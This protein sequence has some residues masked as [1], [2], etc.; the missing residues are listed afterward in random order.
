M[1]RVI[2]AGNILGDPYTLQRYT[3]ML[4]WQDVCTGPREILEE[5]KR[6]L[7]HHKQKGKKQ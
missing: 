1:W 3:L 6:Q 4:G 2:L 5:L 7:A